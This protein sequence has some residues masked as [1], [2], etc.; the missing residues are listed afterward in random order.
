MRNLSL[1]SGVTSFIIGLQLP[2]I[3]G[4]F[5]D[6]NFFGD[7]LLDQGNFFNLTSL[8]PTPPYF[9][10]RSSNGK[11]WADLLAEELKLNPIL[12]TQLNSNI[13][14]QGVN[15]AIIGATTGT[16]NINNRGVNEFPGLQNQ[17]AA[18][19]DLTKINPI[20]PD[21]LY[22]LWAGGNDYNQAFFA[23]ESLTVPL[24]QLPEQIVSNLSNS[25]QSLSDLGAKN[26]LVPNLPDLGSTPFADFLDEFNPLISTQLSNL[27]TAHN[28][29]LEVKLAELDTSLSES[30]INL[31]DINGLLLEIIQNPEPFGISNLDDSCLINFRPTFIFDGVCANPNEYIF[32]DDVH[33]TARVHQIIT[34]RALEVLKPETVP[35]P[36]NNWGLLGLI[37]FGLPLIMNNK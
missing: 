37:F 29:L 22:V 6:I 1:I 17:I 18:F 35:E 27:T 33:P 34:A 24:E 5:T 15:F 8:P 21:G 4:T 14:T 9:E 31:L 16:D 30:T 32:W 7:S 36:N 20:N 2:V 13:P 19:A 23:P 26:F 11:I 28:N 10:G 25:I 12:S 3:A